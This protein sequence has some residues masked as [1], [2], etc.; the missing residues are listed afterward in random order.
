MDKPKTIEEIKDTT[1]YKA[2]RKAARME[3][4]IEQSGLRNLS[5]ESEWYDWYQLGYDS[6]E[7]EK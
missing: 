2:G 3:V 6:V 7:N 5:P 4:P 1:P